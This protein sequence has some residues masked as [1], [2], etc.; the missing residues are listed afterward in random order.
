MLSLSGNDDGQ[1]VF[2]AGSHHTTRSWDTVEACESD[3]PLRGRPD[4]KKA[5][6]CRHV[7]RQRL[8]LHVSQEETASKMLRQKQPSDW[9]PKVTRAKSA[10]WQWSHISDVRRLC[11][12][13]DSIYLFF[14]ACRYLVESAQIWGV[15][16]CAITQAHCIRNDVNLFFGNLIYFIID[17]SR[18]LIISLTANIKT[19]K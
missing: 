8:V 13:V 10:S 5:S 16:I 12:V 14:I 19:R 11:W 9:N 3:A 4:R 1:R 18:H 17:S 7:H 15:Q 2:G 6:Y